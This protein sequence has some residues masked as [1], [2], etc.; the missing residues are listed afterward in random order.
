MMLSFVRRARYLCTIRRFSRAPK[1]WRLRLEALEDRTVLS[2]VSATNFPAGLFPGGAVAGDFTGNGKIDLAVT[3]GS[4]NSPGIA[5]LLGNGDGTFQTP[6]N[7]GPTGTTGAIVEGDFR[8]DGKI[9]LA[10][11]DGTNSVGVLLGNGDG[12]FQPVVNYAVPGVTGLAVGDFNGDSKPDLVAISFTNSTVSVLLGNGDGTFQPAVQTP[13]GNN[14]ISVATADFNG[15]GKLDLVFSN[16]NSGTVSLMAGNGNGTFQVPVPV[17][18]L[19]YVAGN[20]AA[21]DLAGNGKQ[22]LVITS[23]GGPS[24]INVAMGNGD[25]TFQSPVTYTDPF[26]NS[27]PVTLADV[28]GDG[29]PDMLLGNV[30]DSSVS[31]LLNNGDGTFGSPVS[32]NV[33][34]NPQQVV[35]ADFNG[36]G[37]PDVATVNSADVSVL[38]ANSNGTFQG[39]VPLSLNAGAQG[40]RVVE[41]DLSGDGIPDLVATTNGGG[42]S[43]Y[44]GVGKGQFLPAVFYP[45]GGGPSAGIALADLTGDGRLDVVI[46]EPQENDVRVFLNRG[47]GTFQFAGA[48]TSAGTGIDGLAAAD[49]NGDGKIDIVA[50]DTNSNDISVFLGN[51]DGT[52]QPAV[53]Y[54]TAGP[55]P[56]GI[57]LGDFAGTG[58][59]DAAV[60]CDNGVTVLMGNGDGTFQPAAVYGN[61]KAIDIAAGDFNRDGKTDLVV[62]SYGTGQIVVLLGN[63][64]GAFQS[65]VTTGVTMTFP[66]GLL[67]GDFNGDGT[68]DVA[69][70]GGSGNATV[71]VLTGNGDG[72]FALQQVLDTGGGSGY[73]TGGDFNGNGT[74][75]LAV[76]S[77]NGVSIAYDGAANQPTAD[78]F[79]VSAPSLVVPGSPF[80]YTVTVMTPGGTMDKDYRGTVHFTSSDGTAGLP[81]DYMFTGTDAGTHVFSVTLNQPGSQTVTVADSSQPNIAGRAT[82]QVDTAQRLAVNMQAVSA[83][84]Y[85]MTVIITAFGPNGTLDTGYTGTI[86]FTSSDPKAVLPADYT[87]IPGDA[88]SHTFTV[89]FGTSGKRTITVTDITLPA[90]SGTSTTSVKPLLGKGVDYATGAAPIGVAPGDFNGD[91][92]VDLATVN[93]LGSI[94]ILLGQGDGTFGAATVI[95]V[96][97]PTDQL[98]GI[99]VGDF[100]GDGTPD[101]AVVDKT[102]DEVWVLLGDGH[103]GFGAPT[104]DAVGLAPT[105]IATGDFNGDG[106]LDLAVTDSMG[107]DVSVLLNNGSGGFGAAT[108]YAVGPDPDAIVVADFNRDGTPDIAVANYG[109]GTVSILMGNGSGGFAT[110]TQALAVTHAFALAAGDFN[111]DGAPDLVVTSGTSAAARVLFNIGGHFGRASVTVTLPFIATGVVTGDFNGDGFEDFAI[112]GPRVAVMLG[113]GNG[114][115]N[116]SE[117]ATDGTSG[118]G[119]AVADFNGDKAPDLVVAESQA[120]AVTVLLNKD[121]V[122]TSFRINAPAT[123]TAGTQFTFTIDAISQ[124]GGVD[125]SYRGTVHFTS[126]DPSAVLP[127]DFTFRGVPGDHRFKAT[128]NTLG[129]QSLS[130]NDTAVPTVTGQTTIQVLA[131]LMAV[132]IPSL[133]PGNSAAASNATAQPDVP[134]VFGETPGAEASRIADAAFRQ[135]V[136]MAGDQGYA[137]LAPGW[138]T[139]ASQILRVFEDD[140]ALGRPLGDLNA[141]SRYKVLTAEPPDSV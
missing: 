16:A 52:F 87:F 56:G 42:F 101:I 108:Q 75:D 81:A 17:V 111:S 95:P 20:I 4:S 113:E 10:V 1:L 123:V 133:P 114:S 79:T 119:V 62:S 35:V 13:T 53:A 98:A 36:D 116:A 11:V 6:Y 49:L 112:S 50:T 136:R 31:V 2:Y 141:P 22:D 131:G 14:P 72:T 128:L 55:Q 118:A 85:P 24:Q 28:N 27:L 102:A 109:R 46:A 125:P 139:A 96:G 107:N 45:G 29:K 74:I 65:G 92:N 15:D 26:V 93:S 9:D 58:K 129:S 94:S 89:V 137:T 41:G 38:L 91:G 99:A 88:G 83:V 59:I 60:A 82:I 138:M 122:A 34:N 103:G 117:Y 47:D 135:L 97:A 63:G 76:A 73:L 54:A 43:V 40:V 69:V 104:A 124:F 140:S 120:S 110:Q 25:G 66:Q 51:G 23:G 126:S 115:F 132:R 100:N 64:D 61:V 77:G 78:S 39:T 18:T 80:N 68:P 8:G 37:R 127:A 67:V 121:M 7:V 105:A 130:V 21:A 12:T 57:V 19:P 30:T 32:Y 134:A 3:N 71:D 70:G 48:F 44:I 33:D 84:G 106:H 90:L 86:H 5:I